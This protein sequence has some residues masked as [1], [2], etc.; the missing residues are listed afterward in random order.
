MN[1]RP[2]G[3][4][5][6]T[7]TEAGGITTARIAIDMAGRVGPI[8]F[9][10]THRCEE[11]W[12]GN[13]L[14]RLDCTDR[15]NRSSKSV[16]GSLVG[17]KFVVQ[18]TGFKGAVPAEIVPTSWWRSATVR[19]SRILNSR[20][21]KLTPIQ[22]KSLGETTVTIGGVSVPATHYRIRGPANTDVY[23]DKLGR[24]VGTA[25]RIA[26]QSFV[27]QKLTPLSSAPRD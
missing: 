17:G 23:Y 14:L 3:H 11:R 8:G 27:Y 25:F 26:G 2:V 9:S 10:Y 1:G 4:H 20:D 16:S 18:G 22:A 21:G 5:V 6:V 24:W 19:Q 13:Q 15:E 12:R 7:V